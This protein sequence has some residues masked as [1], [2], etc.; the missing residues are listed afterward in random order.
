MGR[1]RNP[2][3]T[4][5]SNTQD[6]LAE[7]A[8]GGKPKLCTVTGIVDRLILKKGFERPRSQDASKSLSSGML[9]KK[10]NDAPNGAA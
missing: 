8:D 3:L 5:S 1:C 10:R 9:G 6:S 7:H 4:A 2:L